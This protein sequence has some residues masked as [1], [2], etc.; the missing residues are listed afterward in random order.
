[1]IKLNGVKINPTIFPDN[2]SQVWK[3]PKEAFDCRTFTVEFEFES[4]SEVMHL[5]QLMDLI[6]F[7]RVPRPI[8]LHMP[9]L[10]YGRQDK[11][12][13]TKE[14]VTFAL[15]SFAKVINMLGFSRVTTLDAH[16]DVGY[17]LIDNFYSI[18]PEN[19][20]INAI[21]ESG[22]DTIAFPD[23]GACNRYI[24]KEFDL[25]MCQNFGMGSFGVI[26][27]HKERDQQ[28]G[29]IKKY[30]T[31][32]DNPKDKNI[33]IIDDI[34]DGGMT[35]KILAKDLL[36]A[37]A[38]SVHLYV[39]HGIFSKGLPTL[40]ASG[41]QRIFTYKGEMRDRSF[42]DPKPPEGLLESELSNI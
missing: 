35:F 26:V 33:I 7:G 28:T 29:Y 18:F 3:V 5:V 41:I 36:E 39:T 22:A 31:E 14:E 12:Q 6:R 1:M 38:K 4:E 40:R 13:S 15:K 37:G 21:K 9:Y 19:E 2:T 10:P 27:G 11:D 23:K 30:N 20:I 24:T 25:A 17:G 42:E 8:N 34:C 16:S 32:G